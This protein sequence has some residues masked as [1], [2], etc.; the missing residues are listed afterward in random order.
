MCGYFFRPDK[1]EGDA[2]ALI[3]HMQR[4]GV[5]VFRLEPTSTRAACASSGRAPRARAV[6]PEGTLYIPLEQPLKHWIQA[7]MG[8]DP[9]EPI[10]FFYDVATWSY[11]LHRGLAS[12][13]FLT[14]SC[15]P[16]WR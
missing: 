5:H 11:P 7:V 2:A 3:E 15:R 14:A 4:Q 16:A 9:F 12:D 1:H 6:L 8:E 10:E 13:G